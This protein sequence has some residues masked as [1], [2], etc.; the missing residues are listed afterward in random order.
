MG[1]KKVVCATVA[2]AA[3][4]VAVAVATSIRCVD[5]TARM[6]QPCVD[7][8]AYALKHPKAMAHFRII[9]YFWPDPSILKSAITMLSEIY[10]PQRYYHLHYSRYPLFVDHWVLL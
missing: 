6:R 5:A 9:Y 10:F 3:G 4:G 7:S 8:H 1:E 2:S